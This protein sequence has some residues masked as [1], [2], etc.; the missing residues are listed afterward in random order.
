VAT[1]VDDS[2]IRELLAAQA[3]TDPLRS[4]RHQIFTDLPTPAYSQ[5][6]F[7]GF[8]PL[9]AA[10]MRPAPPAPSQGLASLSESPTAPANPPPPPSSVQQAKEFASLNML[11]APS[12]PQRPGSA[13]SSHSSSSGMLGVQQERRGR[14]ESAMMGSEIGLIGQ[15]VPVRNLNNGSGN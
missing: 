4:P 1:P 11:A 3:S 10:P 5:T 12:I 15:R 14:R 8:T 9:G 7:G 2:P 13:A 6:T